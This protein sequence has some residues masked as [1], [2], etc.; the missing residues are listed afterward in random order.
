MQPLFFPPV[1]MASWKQ[2]PSLHSAYT[3]PSAWSVLTLWANLQELSCSC[4]CLPS[5]HLLR[6]ALSNLVLGTYFIAMAEPLAGATSRKKNL[7]SLKAPGSPAHHGRE[8]TTVGDMA[9]FIWVVDR[10]QG[11]GTPSLPNDPTSFRPHLLKFPHT[12]KQYN[13]LGNTYLNIWAFPGVGNGQGISHPNFDKHLLQEPLLH[14][15]LGWRS[16][17]L[18]PTSWDFPCV[19]SPQMKF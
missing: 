11:A 15:A 13:M 18:P 17:C 9:H 10:K 12:P 4:V 16:I 6:Q 3:V 8:C 19:C 1:K 2:T 5:I 14:T 7:F